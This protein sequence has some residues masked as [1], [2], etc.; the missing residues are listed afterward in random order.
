VSWRQVST[1]LL[2]VLALAYPLLIYAGL[3]AQLEPRYLA[4]LLALMALG[5]ALVVRE[6]LWWWAAAGALGLALWSCFG[7]ALLPLKLYPVLMNAVFLVLFLVSLAYPPSAVERMAR[8]RE[9]HLPAS[10]VAYTRRV[11][12]VW[13][14]FFVLNGSMALATALWASAEV[15]ALCNGLLSYGAMG[16]LMGA[17]WCARQR[18]RA[19]RGV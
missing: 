1:P 9:P 13:C 10:A 17:E 15:W 12:Q 5:R 11:T 14:V 7:H 8:W 19:R 18:V 2:A 3:M 6:R 4:A 16:L